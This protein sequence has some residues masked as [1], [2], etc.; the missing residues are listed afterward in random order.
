MA[1]ADV[2]DEARPWPPPAGAYAEE[3]GLFQ[4]LQVNGNSPP[5]SPR[6]G[7]GRA[8]TGEAG[9]GTGERPVRAPV[10]PDGRVSVCGKRPWALAVNCFNWQLLR[11]V[12][13]ICLAEESGS[14]RKKGVGERR[15]GTSRGGERGARGVGDELSAGR[16][17]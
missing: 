12:R 16:T 17:R 4:L 9:S 14:P 11:L 1:E 15:G 6:R 10:E 13:A 8:G 5:A 7:G 2:E 3:R